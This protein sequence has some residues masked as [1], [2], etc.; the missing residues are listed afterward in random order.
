MKKIYIIFIAALIVF[1]T[2]IVFSDTTEK[3]TI[4]SVDP[5]NGTLVFCS[6]EGKDVTLKIDKSIGLDTIKAG[7]KV[8]ISVENNVVKNIKPEHINWCPKGF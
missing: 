2:S 7:D 6:S 5:Q 3:G 1:Q 4:K 8:E